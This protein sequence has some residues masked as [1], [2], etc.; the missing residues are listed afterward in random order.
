MVV[1]GVVV[2]V[3][4]VVVGVASVVSGS[5]AAPLRIATA[6]S[7]FFPAITNSAGWARVAPPTGIIETAR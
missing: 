1:V 2:V 4:S 6:G 3:G 7:P 5:G